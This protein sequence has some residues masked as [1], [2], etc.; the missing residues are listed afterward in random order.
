MCVVSVVF[1]KIKWYVYA[2]MHLFSATNWSAVSAHT[3]LPLLSHASLLLYLSPSV[4]HPVW[5]TAG[6]PL[7]FIPTHRWGRSDARWRGN[8]H[9]CSQVKVAKI[10]RCIQFVPRVTTWWWNTFFDTVTDLD[11]QCFKTNSKFLKINLQRKK[12]YITFCNY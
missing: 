9:V 4:V 1:C 8:L 5:R 10:R 11:S 12:A 6:W 2:S 3:H 7:H